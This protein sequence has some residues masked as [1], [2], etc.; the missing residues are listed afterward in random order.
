MFTWLVVPCPRCKTRV[1]VC[2]EIVRNRRLKRISRP[3]R[4]IPTQASGVAGQAVG[5]A[6]GRHFLRVNRQRSRSHVRHTVT[7]GLNSPRSALNSATAPLD[8]QTADRFSDRSPLGR[9]TT[10]S[11][12]ARAP[13]I[14]AASAV[15]QDGFGTGDRRPATLSAA[16]KG[17]GFFKEATRPKNCFTMRNIV[18]NYVFGAH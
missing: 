12:L 3:W 9:K 8:V 18:F 7:D 11:A 16:A 17:I 6:I 15:D 13:A 1:L 2:R 10:A 4:R 14:R 5:D